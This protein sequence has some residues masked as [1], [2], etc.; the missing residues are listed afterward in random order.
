VSDT[1]KDDI[2]PGAGGHVA[3]R[4]WCEAFR[5]GVPASEEDKHMAEMA[6]LSHANKELHLRLR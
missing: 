1:V 6:A 2:Y 4:P 3:P 5:L